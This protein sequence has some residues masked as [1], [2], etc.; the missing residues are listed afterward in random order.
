MLDALVLLL[1]SAATQ[2]GVRAEVDA[3]VLHLVTLVQQAVL[4]PAGPPKTKARKRATTAR[5]GASLSLLATGQEDDDTAANGDGDGDGR[6]ST[7]R[8]RS[9][10]ARGPG[11]S[12]LRWRPA[13]RARR[14]GSGRGSSL[15]LPRRRRSKTWRACSSARRS[16]GYGV[17]TDDDCGHCARRAGRRF[18]SWAL[19]R[20]ARR[21]AT[22]ACRRP[23]PSSRN[24]SGAAPLWALSAL[25]PFKWLLDAGVDRYGAP[26]TPR[27]RR[28]TSP[29]LR[30]DGHGAAKPEGYFTRSVGAVGGCRGCTCAP[31]TMRCASCTPPSTQSGGGQRE[32]GGGAAGGGASL[33]TR[34]H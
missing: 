7:S 23:T 10:P 27:W 33:S 31:S 28:T 16:L 15:S 3:Y 11:R 13:A 18:G 25:S 5:G 6:T 22:R 4:G 19:R 34:G 26:R 9:P 20:R 29:T 32:R 14:T 24:S 17:S 8:R 30:G 12:S 2:Y 1:Q 21:S